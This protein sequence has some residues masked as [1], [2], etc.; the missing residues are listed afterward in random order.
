MLLL[1]EKMSPQNRAGLE[2]LIY[3]LL[4]MMYVA[5]NQR[6]QKYDNYPTLLKLT[7]VATEFKPKKSTIH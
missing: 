3:S 7:A 6:L 5:L 4:T 1:Y 2:L